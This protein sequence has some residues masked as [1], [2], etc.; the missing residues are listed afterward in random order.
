M[1]ENSQKPII[2]Y[3]QYH[4]QKM[5]QK[6]SHAGGWYAKDD[7][8]GSGYSIIFNALKDNYIIRET[9]EKITN[10]A[11]KDISI[12]II[13]NPDI[14]KYISKPNYIQEEEI[15]AIASFIHQCGGLLV[16]GNSSGEVELEHLNKLLRKFGFQ[17]NDN[18]TGEIIVDTNENDFIKN[19]SSFAYWNGCTI[20][21]LQETNTHS[22]KSIMEID[23]P[24]AGP[25]IVLSKYGKGSVIAVG[26]AG[27][28]LNEATKKI[29]DNIEIFIQLVNYLI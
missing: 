24:V 21:L 29:K 5:T 7:T 17:F 27:C 14:P 28:F 1:K 4:H 10:A 16:I 19:I 20:K 18:E 12:L 9:E 22:V 13:V 8:T 2:L 3:D 23:D 15:E 11:L 6:A 26:D 25:I